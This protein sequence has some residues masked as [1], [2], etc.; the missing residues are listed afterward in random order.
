MKFFRN[1]PEILAVMS[2]RSDGNM[3]MNYD[4]KSGKA[5]KKTG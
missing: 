5:K 1:F 3:K 4:L 2:A